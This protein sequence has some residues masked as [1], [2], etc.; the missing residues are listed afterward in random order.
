MHIF[1]LFEFCAF[2]WIH[3][4]IIILIIIIMIISKIMIISMIMIMII[5]TM[6]R[7][8]AQY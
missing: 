5:M 2:L 8:G 1:Q 3:Q 6:I 4:V 7:C